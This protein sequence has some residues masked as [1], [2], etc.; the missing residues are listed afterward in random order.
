MVHGL[1]KDI[2]LYECIFKFILFVNV[3]LFNYNK[4]VWFSANFLAKLSD[5]LL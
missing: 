1:V 2:K 4:L 3:F 5:L